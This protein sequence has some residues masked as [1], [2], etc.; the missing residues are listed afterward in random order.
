MILT[1]TLDCFRRIFCVSSN[2]EKLIF[3]LYLQKKR[4]MNMDFTRRG[5]SIL[6]QCISGHGWHTKVNNFIS[7][8]LENKWK[9]IL[10]KEWPAQEGNGTVDGDSS[11]SVPALTST[12]DQVQLLKSRT[13]IVPQIEEVIS[14]T[15]QMKRIQ[16]KD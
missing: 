6:A 14:L 10:T 2:W 11:D 3:P 12:L 4:D 13:C 15:I 16:I 9:T 5:F 7:R 1:C 8:N